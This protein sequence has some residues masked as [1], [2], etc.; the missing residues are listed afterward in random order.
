[1]DEIRRRIADRLAELG[2]SQSWLS[3]KLGRNRGYM[4]EYFQG[5]PANLPC[6]TRVEIAKL[7]ELPPRDLGIV[8]F[9]E[10]PPVQRGGL[11]EDAERYEPPAGHFLARAPNVSYFIMRSRA[12]DQHPRRIMPGHVLAFDINHIDPKTITS[13][14]IVV[15]QVFDKRELLHHIGTIIRQFIAPNKLITNSSVENEIA[16]LDDPASP[17][18]I[19]IKGVLLSV[20]DTVG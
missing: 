16:S 8:P 19:V 18:M 3:S 2:H 6:E 1:M 4:Y 7:L 13:G 20:V 12:L 15:A 14:S 9:A 17:H 11:S 10:A 5:S